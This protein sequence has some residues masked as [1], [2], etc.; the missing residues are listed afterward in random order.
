M[1]TAKKTT[2]VLNGRAYEA[3]VEIIR[4][5]MNGE[6]HNAGQEYLRIHIP[7][8]MFTLTVPRWCVSTDIEA[9]YTD[10]LNDEG[11]SI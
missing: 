3:T 1:I 4:P 11:R 6:H 7:K 2:V 9:V 5:Q 10:G 8:D